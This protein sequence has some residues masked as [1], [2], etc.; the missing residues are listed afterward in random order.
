MT[1]SITASH[2]AN[3]I[4][5]ARKTGVIVA[6]NGKSL[7]EYLDNW[8]KITD[9][10]EARRAREALLGLQVQP[11]FTLVE[12]EET[13][14]W[15]EAI[16][17]RLPT[18]EQTA[19]CNIRVRF[20]EGMKGELAP[21]KIAVESQLSTLTALGHTIT[22]ASFIKMI[23]TQL[24][25]HRIETGTNSANSEV[26]EQPGVEKK[27]KPNVNVT[28]HRD[29]EQQEMRR[30]FACNGNHLIDRCE[31]SKCEFCNGVNCG[32][33]FPNKTSCLVKYVVEH[34]WLP[35]NVEGADG[36]DMPANHKF[37]IVDRARR[38]KQRMDE[39]EIKDEKTA[40]ESKEQSNYMRVDNRRDMTASEIRAMS[41]EDEVCFHINCMPR[42]PSKRTF[43]ETNESTIGDVI[44][45]NDATNEQCASCSN[46]EDEENDE[47]AV[48]CGN[49]GPERAAKPGT[50][51]PA[52]Y[53][54][55]VIAPI[56]PGEPTGAKVCDRPGNK[57]NPDKIQDYD[58]AYKRAIESGGHE[59][60]S[61]DMNW[62]DD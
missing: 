14:L 35:N 60:K 32:I 33:H 50:A 6:S 48:L 1:G 57:P 53:P 8:I 11:Q 54:F 43:D 51:T 15:A 28:Y 55:W 42:S 52:N 46:V 47:I 34:G 2:L 23:D 30:C 4:E 12:L 37:F 27:I 3:S 45:G 58:D 44:E 26:F 24:A 59:N 29:R 9:A 49:G 10:D 39:E 5:H 41:R 38:I 40:S 25:A 56:A 21:R 19:E 13:Y 61:I 22:D 36:S 16:I 31:K 17:Q 18:S 20:L 7:I 62:A